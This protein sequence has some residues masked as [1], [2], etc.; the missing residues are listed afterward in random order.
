[1]LVSVVQVAVFV[2]VWIERGLCPLE[3]NLDNR[4]RGDV[5]RFNLSAREMCWM[6]E[7][8]ATEEN[9][10]I[11]PRDRDLIHF[12]ALYPPCMRRDAALMDAVLARQRSSDES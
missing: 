10:W 5:E 6:V 4:F 3:H 7:Q 8:V 1:M 12:G 9:Q 2:V 11:G